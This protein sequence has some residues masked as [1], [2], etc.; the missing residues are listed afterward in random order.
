MCNLPALMSYD[1][2]LSGQGQAMYESSIEWVTNTM[3][4]SIGNRFT[5]LPLLVEEEPR[6]IQGE[7]LV[8][9]EAR[10]EKLSC[11]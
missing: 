4:N 11:R 9:S 2:R 8:S 10:D 1:Y 6:E 3:Q 7:R 5:V